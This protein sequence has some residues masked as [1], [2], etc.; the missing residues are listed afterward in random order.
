M[1]LSVGLTRGC[2]RRWLL[3][4]KAAGGDLGSSDVR[5]PAGVEGTGVSGRVPQ[6]SSCAAG[7]AVEG[8]LVDL[9]TLGCEPVTHGQSQQVFLS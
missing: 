7:F 4:R 9:P 1:K 3:R 6:L 5:Q 2:E 8:L